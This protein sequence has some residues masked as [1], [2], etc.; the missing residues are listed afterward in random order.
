MS[1]DGG[2]VNQWLV[3]KLAM[4]CSTAP[5]P[6]QLVVFQNKAQHYYLVLCFAYGYSY[7]FDEVL[8]TLLIFSFVFLCRQESITMWSTLKSSSTDES[9]QWVLL[10]HAF[11]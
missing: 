1:A 7:I 9:I 5:V 11:C 2:Q 3:A 4:L 8:F 6:D 10:F